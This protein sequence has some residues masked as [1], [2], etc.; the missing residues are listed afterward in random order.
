MGQKDLDNSLFLIFL[1]DPFSFFR[2]ACN[3]SLRLSGSG[4]TRPLALFRH[5]A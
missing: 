2:Y 5:A 3:G 4:T 1:E